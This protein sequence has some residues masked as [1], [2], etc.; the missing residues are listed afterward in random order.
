MN[1]HSVFVCVCVQGPPGVYQ[2]EDLVSLV[3]RDIK[4]IFTLC[5]VIAKQ[6]Q[7]VDQSEKTTIHVVG[8]S[9]TQIILN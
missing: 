3:P 8:F 9:F 4:D 2:G 7:K 1:S 5:K 6:Q